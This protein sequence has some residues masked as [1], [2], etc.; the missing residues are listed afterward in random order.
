MLV[1]H[2][3]EVKRLEVVHDEL[4]S[5][6][7]RVLELTIQKLRHKKPLGENTVPKKFKGWFK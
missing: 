5:N 7:A 2:E 6:I 4:I 1:W 3:W